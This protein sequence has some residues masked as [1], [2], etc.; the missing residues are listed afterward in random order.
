MNEA[1][2]LPPFA[3]H[4]FE[5]EGA[6]TRLLGSRCGDCGRALFPRAPLCP[7]DGSRTDPIAL[8]TRA[9]LHSF[10]VVRIKP[11]F[12]LPAPYAVAYVDLEGLDLR[13]FALL[14]PDAIGIY[15][16]GMPLTLWSGALGV[17][18]AGDACIRPYFQPAG[19]V[20]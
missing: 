17:D 2:A 19:A 10:T 15:H 14:D 16:I 3:E 12:G 4:I 18:L 8:P 6:T 9:T 5:R 20:A 7:H 11:P 13:L 1:A